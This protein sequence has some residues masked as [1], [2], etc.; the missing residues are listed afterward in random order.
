MP[1]VADHS[2]LTRPKPSVVQSSATPVTRTYIS[3]PRDRTS[4]ISRSVSQP[5]GI[6]SYSSP[7]PSSQVYTSQPYTNTIGSYSTALPTSYT[8]QSPTINRVVRAPLRSS[9]NITSTPLRSYS[10]A[11]PTNTIT[12]SP[13]QV[14]YSSPPVQYSTPQVQYSS[15]PVQYSSRPSVQYTSLATPIQYTSQPVQ[16]PTVQYSSPVQYTN[17]SRP[18]RYSQY[19]APSYT[20]Q[21]LVAPLSTRLPT[22]ERITHTTSKGSSGI[23]TTGNRLRSSSFN[24]IRSSRDGNTV[25]VYDTPPVDE[26]RASRIVVSS[27]KIDYYMDE[28]T[29]QTTYHQSV[30]APV[31]NYSRTYQSAP[32]ILASPSVRYTSGPTYSSPPIPIQPGLPPRPVTSYASSSYRPQSNAPQY[33]NYL[34]LSAQ[35]I[36][37]GTTTSQ[38][39]NV[40]EGRAK[41]AHPVL[42]TQLGRADAENHRDEFEVLP[43]KTVVQREEVKANGNS[44]KQITK[45]KT[46]ESIDPTSVQDRDH[47]DS[48]DRPRELEE[49]ENRESGEPKWND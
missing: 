9:E 49:D 40:K 43:T 7:P 25:E 39:Q 11:A 18:V 1:V 29:S 44:S 36:N 12:Y 20:S 48:E 33:S 15:P 10:T 27:S 46:H 19:V 17:V 47:E 30:M 13:S 26:L 2:I 21:P 31:A 16:Y 42:A 3:A 34:P 32:R 23:E 38:G 45:Q 24:V 41:Y 14:Q 8:T 6:G 35:G 5:V 4:Y 28:P 37:G 22:Q